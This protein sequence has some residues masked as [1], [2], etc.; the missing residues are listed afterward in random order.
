MLSPFTVWNSRIILFLPFFPIHISK[1]QKEP[2]SLSRKCADSD[3][4]VGIQSWKL[5]GKQ[6]SCEYETSEWSLSYWARI[7]S[8]LAAISVV[9]LFYSGWEKF[10]SHNFLYTRF[11]PSVFNIP[12]QK[13]RVEGD[14]KYVRHDDVNLTPFNRVP[15]LPKRV[16]SRNKRKTIN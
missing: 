2:A 15:E 14:T 5:N 11:L 16:A 3:E 1:H 9:F 6:K 7:F 8:G 13:Q 4:V 12:Q 10:R